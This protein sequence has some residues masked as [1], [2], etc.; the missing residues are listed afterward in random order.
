MTTDPK[1]FELMNLELDGRATDGQRATLK[2]HLA[3]N[4]EAARTYEALAG[5]IRGLDAVPAVE[6]PAHL[7]PRVMAAIEQAAAPA[8]EHGGWMPVSLRRFLPAFGAGLVTGVFLFAAVQFGR[9]A[10]VDPA[11][12]SGSMT[13]PSQTGAVVGS[14]DLT[15]VPGGLFGRIE[16]STRPGGTVVDARLES[17]EPVDWV[18]ETGPG[19]RVDGVTIPSGSPAGFGASPHEVHGS[20]AG[21]GTYRITLTGDADPVQTIVLKIVKDGHVVA[22]RP[23][24]PVH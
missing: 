16:L 5:V 1:L 14:I 21:D 6:P 11:M 18:L 4:P 23:A 15:G 24:V 2:A 22:E 13:P 7:H 19:L 3:S 17:A 20:H 8:R 9:N 12:L 10:A